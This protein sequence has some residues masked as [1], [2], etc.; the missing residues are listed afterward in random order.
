MSLSQ[1]DVVEIHNFDQ[2]SIV[3]VD[4]YEALQLGDAGKS[5]NHMAPSTTHDE[6][7]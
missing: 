5:L 1:R 7:I 3:L 4:L 2:E 6:D